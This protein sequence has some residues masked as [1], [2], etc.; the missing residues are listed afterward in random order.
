MNSKKSGDKVE[1]FNSGACYTIK[2]KSYIIHM[3]LGGARVVNRC[4]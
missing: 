4:D 3:F 1:R 2:F